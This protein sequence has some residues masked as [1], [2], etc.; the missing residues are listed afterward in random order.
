M[1]LQNLWLVMIGLVMGMMQNAEANCPTFSSPQQSSA[2]IESLNKGKYPRYKYLDDV[3]DREVAKGFK[4]SNGNKLQIITYKNI[5][6][7]EKKRAKTDMQSNAIH[8]KCCYRFTSGGKRSKFAFNKVCG[9]NRE[10]F[11]VVSK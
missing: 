2:F 8:T 10:C 11:C 1:R 4:A 9:K 3:K 7:A 5:G 6:R